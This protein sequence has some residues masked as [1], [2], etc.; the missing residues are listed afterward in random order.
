[1]RP[2]ISPNN[3]INVNPGNN[4]LVITDYADNLQRLSRIIASMDV[5]NAS[6]VEIMPLKHA[7][8]SDIVPLLQRLLEG[9]SATGG[10]AT[11]GAPG[12]AQ[13]DNSYRTTVLAEPRTNSIMLRAANPA[14]LSQARS[15][16]AKLDMPSRGGN[17]TSGNIHVVYLKNADATALA[18]TLRAALAGQDGGA[19][20]AT[21]LS[22]SN[23]GSSGRLSSGGTSIGGSTNSS[24]SLGTSSG[25]TG[26]LGSGNRLNTG[27]SL[28][29]ANETGSATGGI[30]QADT[31]TN[32]LIITAPEPLYREIRAVI[33]QLDSRRAQ[34]LV[35]SLIAEVNAEKAAQFGVQWQSLLGQGNNVVGLLGSN[36]T[37]GGANLFNIATGIAAGQSN[38]NYAGA[39]PSPGMNAGIAIKHNGDYVLGALANLLQASG[40]GNIL[41]TPN[42]LT[43]DNQEAQILV[44]QNVPFVTGSY[45]S[46]NGTNTANPFTTVERKDV[47]LTLRVRPQINANGTVKLTIYQET[48]NV[49]EGTTKETNGPSTSKR[50]IESTVLVDDGSIIVIGGLLQDQY[51]GSV[52][53]VPYLGDIPGIGALFRSDSRTRKKTNLMV[54]LRPVVMR[55]ADSTRQVSLDRYDLMR[56]LQISGQPE[57]SNTVPINDSPVMTAPQQQTSG[58][59]LGYS[60]TP[61]LHSP[62]LTVTPQGMRFEP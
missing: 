36:F 41:S 51:S 38:G 23:L 13:S 52:Q 6:D 20:P 1:L 27:T 49:I 44:G 11:A 34:V 26:S 18:T 29:S 56:G 3:T 62:A 4:S 24:G 19:N 2:L 9:G 43:L 55:D 7:I 57:R 30:I 54:F 59:P 35:E 45:A 48:S 46:T 22:S 58:T 53:K 32:S 50:S 60:E 14:R 17:G 21:N 61:V 37:V 31:A 15:L 47:G 10:V 33:D 16:I 28:S 40:E 12:Q 25:N 42:L 39:I 8:A 5:S